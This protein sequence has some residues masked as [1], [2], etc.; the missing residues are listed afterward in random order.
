MEM[1]GGVE[2]DADILFTGVVAVVAQMGAP[3]NKLPPGDVDI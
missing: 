1:H 3:L 2:V